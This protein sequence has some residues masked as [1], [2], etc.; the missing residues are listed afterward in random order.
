MRQPPIED[1]A[2]LVGDGQ[3]W[4]VGDRADLLT[5]AK[6]VSVHDFGDA[7]ILPGLVNVHCHLDYTAMS[8]QLAPSASFTEW[9]HSITELK[10]GWG[11]S[12]FAQSWLAGARMLLE[13]GTTTVG[14]IEAAPD[15]L[16]ELW[17]ATPLR[18][19]SFVELI[20]M[21]RGRDPGQVLAPA[22]AK[23][24]TLRHPR[25]RVGLAPHAPY[26]TTPGL[27]RLCAEVARQH[28]W[29]LSTHAAESAEEYEMFRRRRGPLIEWLARNDRELVDC[30]IGSPVQ[31]LE[32]CGLLGPRLTVA[33]ANYLDPGD[34]QCLARHGVS[35]AHCPRSHEYFDHGPFPYKDL[36]EAGVNVCL[37][38]DSL[39]TVLRPRRAPVALDL[40]AEM[41]AF[42]ARYPGVDPERVLTMTTVQPARALGLEGKVGDLRV[43]AH[44][45][46]IVVRGPNRCANLFENLIHHEGPV[47]ASMIGGVWRF[48]ELRPRRS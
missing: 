5:H 32:R 42:A 9:I 2:L 7:V 1:G 30:G 44:A 40:F 28:R 18:V 22:L 26:S 21:R 13:H 29:R 15:L 11:Y 48:G 47:T 17:D 35:V 39:A 8:G 38:T 27:L 16:P 37:A 34:A 14:D 23:I 20:G 33:H 6:G 24:A 43:G 3:I 36:T 12:D 4:V 25:C 10:L 45:D 41:R 19:F 46:L 31:H